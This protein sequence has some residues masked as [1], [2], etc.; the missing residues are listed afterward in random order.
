MTCFD[1]FNLVLQ[2]QTLSQS[3]EKHA[4]DN[5]IKSTEI[6]ERLESHGETAYKMI[7]I[8]WD[9]PLTPKQQLDINSILTYT[10]N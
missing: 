2:G 3:I 7:N 4:K 1:I 9:T 8:V 5:H 10:K 6:Y